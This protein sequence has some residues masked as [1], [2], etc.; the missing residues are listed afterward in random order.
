MY[1]PNSTGWWVM[2]A[3]MGPTLTAQLAYMRG[4]ELIGPSRASMF[5]CLVPAL[6]AIFAVMILDEPFLPY[7]AV[8]LILGVSGVYLAEIRPKLMKPRMACQSYKLNLKSKIIS[9]A[10]AYIFFCY[11][12]ALLTLFTGPRNKRHQFFFYKKIGTPIP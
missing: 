3:T 6:G 2:L 4:V 5:P 10:I 7:H 1:W 9:I 12:Y 11:V 8:A